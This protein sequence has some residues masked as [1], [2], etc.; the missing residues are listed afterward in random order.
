MVEKGEKIFLKK[1]KK[2][3]ANCF[4][5]SYSLVAGMKVCGSQQCEAAG[6]QWG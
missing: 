1:K 5:R 6:A 4:C 3:I 2:Y